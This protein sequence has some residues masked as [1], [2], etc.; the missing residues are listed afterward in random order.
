MRLPRAIALF[1]ALAA[2]SAYAIDTAPDEGAED[3]KETDSYI[4]NRFS[5]SLHGEYAFFLQA[6]DVND[7]GSGGVRVG[8]R[9]TRWAELEFGADF[10]TTALPAHGHDGTVVDLG[11][12]QLIPI[13]LDV[14]IDIT[15]IDSKIPWPLPWCR[16]MLIGGLGFASLHVREEADDPINLKH[17]SG[18]PIVRGGVGVEFGQADQRVTFGAEWIYTWVAHDIYVDDPTFNMPGKL[19]MDYWTLGAYV[20][21]RF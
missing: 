15:H 7:T 13:Y 20:S 12:A 11:R 3:D 19:N 8:F 14:R 21:L 2:S 1:L 10:L 4:P 6:R 9:L 5:I 17:K 16:P 18:G